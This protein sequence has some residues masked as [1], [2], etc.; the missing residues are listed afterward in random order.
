M[1]EKDDT[2]R[3]E[4]GY[5]VKD[6]RA[7]TPDGEPKETAQPGPTPEPSRAAGSRRPFGEGTAHGSG[8]CC[9]PD[10][11]P[12]I[13]SAAESRPSDA[14]PARDAAEMPP[15][16]FGQFILSLATATLFHL[17]DAHEEGKEPPPPNLPL[18]KE[19]IDIIE[20]LQEKTKG[21]LSK[22]ETAFIEGILFDLRMR[23]VAKGNKS[24]ITV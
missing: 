11:S 24:K 13:P 7:F 18:A 22:E 12:L 3:G 17:G 14:G 1:A 9:G 21:N 6:K 20:M 2:N 23:Y 4:K 10:G 16:E 5:E 19:T 15:V 8:S